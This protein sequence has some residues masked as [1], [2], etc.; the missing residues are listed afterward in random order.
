MRRTREEALETRDRILDCAERLFVDKGV[1]ETTLSDIATAAGVTRGAIY[2]HFANK[3]DVFSAVVAR[4]KLPMDALFEAANHPDAADPIAVLRSALAA[5]LREMAADPRTSRVF[6]ILLTHHQS[7]E[8]DW[9]R[10]RQSQSSLDARARIARAV[11]NAV[12]KQQLPTDLDIDRAAGL[13]KASLSGVMRDWL[14]D[15]GSL[16]LPHDAERIA[17]A[18]LDMLRF[19]PG[20]RKT[21]R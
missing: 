9:L 10:A 1:P 15:P 13:L 5:C 20:L 12:A 21:A 11:R 3:T 19:S 14:L 17:D 8:G 18:L 6:N 7:G 2:G 4:V 16:R